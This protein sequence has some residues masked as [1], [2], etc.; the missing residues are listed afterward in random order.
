M[1]RPRKRRREGEAEDTVEVL[2]ADTP[3]VTIS[4]GFPTIASFSDVGQPPH[5]HDSSQVFDI[6]TDI[7][8]PSNDLSISDAFGVSPL[9]SLE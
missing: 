2:P 7:T 8:P 6:S 9:S 1:G 5:L 4:N 3:L